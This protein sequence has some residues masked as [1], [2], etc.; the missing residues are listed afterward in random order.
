MKKIETLYLGANPTWVDISSYDEVL[1]GTYEYPDS[2]VPCILFKRNGVIVR[3]SIGIPF[4]AI[5]KGWE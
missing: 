5:Y 1:D 2:V 4:D 3:R